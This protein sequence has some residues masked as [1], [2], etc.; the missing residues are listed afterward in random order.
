M[1]QKNL[2]KSPWSPVILI[3]LI[4]AMIFTF[5]SRRDADK[6][7]AY[8]QSEHVETDTGAATE[9]TPEIDTEIYTDN[10]NGLSLQIPVGWQQVTMDGYPTFIHNASGASVQIQV[11]EYDPQVNMQDK[12]SLSSWCAQHGY[13]FTSFSRVS[14][15]HYQLYYQ[16][17]GNATYDYIED[18]HWDRDKIVRLVCVFKDEHYER[19][20]TYYDT[21]LASFSW[22]T[23][24]PVP[25][26]FYLYYNSN[27][28]FE[29]GI[30]SSWSFGE[31]DSAIVAT[32]P[33]SGAALTITAT[34]SPG[35]LEGLTAVDMANLIGAGKTG[36]MMRSF[37]T[38]TD[39]ASASATYV[40]GE[41]QFQNE[42]Y[43][44]T[45]GAYLFCLSVDYEEGTIDNTVPKNCG[46][47]FRMFGETGSSEAEGTH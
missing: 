45:N 28:Q 18:T 11:K 22:D 9:E 12:V 24:N 40:N 34:E 1:R 29:A 35:T 21:I 30:P 2:H 32:D 46:S 26:G 13:S 10:E 43:L 14:P 37:E 33:E 15:T 31:S 3:I 42:T 41:I 5:F 16:N 38:D 23:S 6:V 27:L 25:E 39:R 47:L 19:L 8:T 44:F 20:A 17:Q 7:P 36:F 4:V